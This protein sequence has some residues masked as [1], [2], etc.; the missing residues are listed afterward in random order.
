VARTDAADPREV[1]RALVD[2]LGPDPAAV[3]V[4]H[5][6]KRDGAD[7][8]RHMVERLGHEA[9]IGCSSAGEISTGALGHGTVVAA[10]LGSER[11]KRAAVACQSL[12]PSLPA[13]LVA[14]VRELEEKLGSPLRDLDPQRHVGLIFLDSI[15][16]IEEAVHIHLGNVAPL[17]RFVG[18]SAADELVFAQVQVLAGARASRNG[19]ALM[20]LELEGPFE[21][22]KGCHFGPV[23]P[24]RIVTRAEGRLLH[25]LDGRPA[26]EVYCEHIGCAP[27]Q[28]NF[29]TLFQNPLGLVIG[30]EAWLRQAAPPFRTGGSVFLGC[31]IAEGSAVHFMRPSAPLIEHTRGLLDQVRGRLG[32]IRGAITFDCALRRLEL[33]AAGMGPAYAALFSFPTAGYFTHGESFVGHM[34]QT[35]T[36]LF[37][38]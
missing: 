31:E 17:L 23:G 19:F 12:A 37:F 16:G 27:E 34:H 10:A 7:L 32:E 14:A 21:I 33:D 2:A 36:G 8:A 26:V 6:P 25:E 18:G 24:E 38:G 5:D 22:V 15:H 35:F 30:G 11:V 9:V 29:E 1:A 4:F 3:V 13:A 28:F 20:V